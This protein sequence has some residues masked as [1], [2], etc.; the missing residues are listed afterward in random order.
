MLSLDDYEKVPKDEDEESILKDMRKAKIKIQKDSNF[1]QK[2]IK[3]WGRIGNDDGKI[4][5]DDPSH[6]IWVYVITDQ[7]MGEMKAIPYE[8]FASDVVLEFAIPVF[9]TVDGY[10]I[11]PYT[12]GVNLI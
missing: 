10:V 8:N 12:N 2:E 1:M 7:N 4:L 6:S 3:T 11:C 9:V 5:C